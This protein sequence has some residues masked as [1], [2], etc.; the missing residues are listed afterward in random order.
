MM[1]PKKVK[2][3]WRKFY[4]KLKSLFNSIKFKLKKL[5]KKWILKKKYKNRKIKNYQKN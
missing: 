5:L 2:V 4:Q 3:I 1:N